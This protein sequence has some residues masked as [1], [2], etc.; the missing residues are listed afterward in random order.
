MHE[1]VTTKQLRSRL[2]GYLK[3][4]ENGHT[5]VV[6]RQGQPVAELRPYST[7]GR[8]IPEAEQNGQAMAEAA[9]PAGLSSPPA[10]M[11]GLGLTYYQ[12]HPNPPGEE[13]WPKAE[14]EP[15]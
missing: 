4:V 3:Q 1:S 8:A 10:D 12:C 14:E 9:P 6:V 7:N 2:G 11:R 13:S 5:L 15:A